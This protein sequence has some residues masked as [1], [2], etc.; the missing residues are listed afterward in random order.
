MS[1]NACRTAIKEIKEGLNE[2][3]I[4]IKQIDDAV[5][6]ILIYKYENITDNY[7]DSSFLNKTEYNDVL[8]KIKCD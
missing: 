3:K 7:L 2:G 1:K 4:T 6:K 8:K 5:K